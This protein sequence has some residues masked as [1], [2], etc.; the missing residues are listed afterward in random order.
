LNSLTKS[1]K[2]LITE[3]DQIVESAGLDYK[4]VENLENEAR[5][6]ILRNIKDQ[7]VRSTIIMDYVLIDEHL[8][9][10]IIN[11]YFGSN[12]SSIKLWRTKK[13]KLFNYYIL[14]KLYLVNKL[15]HAKEIINFPSGIISKIK[16]INDLRNALAHSFFPENR[17]VTVSYENKSVYNLD[18]FKKYQNDVDEVMKFLAE[19]VWKVKI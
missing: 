13:F 10:I 2:N 15:D 3:I 1:Q 9:Q 17:R 5:I 16:K 19:K 6:A 8:C 14:E 7:V 18:G 11:Y 4:N 12:S